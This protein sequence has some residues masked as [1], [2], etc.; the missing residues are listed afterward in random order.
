M[1]R[2]FINNK[3]NLEKNPRF[4][5]LVESL[6]IELPP[7][8]EIYTNP[9][10]NG[11]N[12]DIVLLNEEKGI[13]I[14]D[15]GLKP[16]SPEPRI[17]F[18]T[19]QI[20]NLYCPRAASISK[21][22]IYS[23]FADLEN[24]EED[25]ELNRKKLNYINFS[26][27]SKSNIDDGGAISFE[28][29]I[30]LLTKD[31]NN[32]SKDLANDLRSWL[33]ISDFKL[34]DDDEIVTLDRYQRQLVDTRSKNGYRRIKGS[35]GSGKTLV[36][37]HKTAK[38][39]AQGK[40]VLMLTYNITLVN[41]IRSLVFK[42][43]KN[44]RLSEMEGQGEW[45]IHHFHNYAKNY[46][47]NI[48]HEG[49]WR[50]AY[51]I[52][53][54]REDKREANMVI[55]PELFLKHLSDI[56]YGPLELFDAILVD[57]GSDFVPNMW[58]CCRKLVK[59]DGEAYLVKDGSQDIFENEKSWTDEVMKDS[60]FSGPWNELKE[61]YRIPFFYI[62]KIKNFIDMHLSDDTNVNYPINEQE[63]DMFMECNT[64]WY[65]VNEAE[66]HN[67]CI[68]TLI[69]MLPL[70]EEFS[71]SNILFLTSVKR[72]GLKIVKDLEN[73]GI[74][75]AHTFYNQDRASKVSFELL[76]EKIKATTVYSIKGFEGPVIVLQIMPRGPGISTSKQLK[77]VY[78][79][80]T[81]LRLG[82]NSKCHINIIC[83]D[84]ALK[85]YGETWDEDFY[86]L[87]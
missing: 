28:E 81:R 39:V 56:A 46:F 84:P 55:I 26:I 31:E 42:A 18:I 57:E 32:F 63:P 14:I 10:V 2:L 45:Q 33:R 23:S 21:K 6:D 15:A 40:S 25:I 38:L 72:Q 52:D 13:H 41:Y 53:K 66:N 36:L 44:Y 62:P 71:Y 1:N 34:D 22:V 37:A 60:G 80:L 12:P 47:I 29:A 65:Q 4:A 70:T 76:N 58:N 48:G 20:G 67:L 83:S 85:S 9:F 17:I 54:D 19:E 86:N 8:W 82:M 51:S 30:P 27:I 73:H 50:N 61:T 79:A 77:L 69:K 74:E 5:F 3:K 59:E 16:F 49:T 43:L 11:L 35:A 68:K 24:I 64:A 7:E 78:T 87:L 75:V